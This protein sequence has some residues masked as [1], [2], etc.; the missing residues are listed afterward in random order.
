[1]D[2]YVSAASMNGNPNIEIGPHVVHHTT[3][4]RDEEWRRVWY[5]PN[6]DHQLHI[7]GSCYRYCPRCGFRSDCGDTV[8]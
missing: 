6:C 4:S 7:R 5:C 8:G 3:G 2:S 1:M